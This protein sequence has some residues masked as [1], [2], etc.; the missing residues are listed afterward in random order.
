MAPIQINEAAKRAANLRVLQKTD[1]TTI[2][3]IGSA[4]H[5]VLYEFNTSAVQWEKQNVEGMYLRVA[6]LNIW[7]KLIHP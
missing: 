7:I 3:I 2:D 5:A 6:D 4:P 1:P